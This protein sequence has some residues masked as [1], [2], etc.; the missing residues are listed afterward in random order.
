M[1]LKADRPTIDI[2]IWIVCLIIR[3]SVDNRK[4]TAAFLGVYSGR[5]MRDAVRFCHRWKLVGILIL[6]PL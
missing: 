3:V 1:G 4:G 2:N 5:N 6:F